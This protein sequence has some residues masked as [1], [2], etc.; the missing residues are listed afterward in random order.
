MVVSGCVFRGERQEEGR[1]G[2]GAASIE[3]RRRRGAMRVG[4]GARR[5]SGVA[6]IQTAHT[7]VAYPEKHLRERRAVVAVD[8][9]AQVEP[10]ADV[11]DDFLKAVLLDA[12]RHTVVVH[13][14]RKG[15]VR[16]AVAHLVVG[17]IKTAES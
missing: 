14:D 16:P 13:S 8:L 3:P 7:H 1:A 6:A 11:L 12:V 5:S 9:L 4:A 17:R 15:Q 2:E 10:A